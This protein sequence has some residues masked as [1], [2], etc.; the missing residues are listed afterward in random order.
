MQPANRQRN[1]IQGQHGQEVECDD[2]KDLDRLVRAG[3]RKTAAVGAHVDKLDLAAMRTELL[4]KLDASK[5]LFP[6]F[7]DA[8]DG[9]GNEKVG[10]WGKGGKAELLAV[11][12]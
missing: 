2:I 6:E 9:A 10:V 7:D 3:S 12:K 1:I 11:H 4:D 5:D 8:V